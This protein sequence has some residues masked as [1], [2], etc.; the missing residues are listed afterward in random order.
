MLYKVKLSYP[1]IIEIKGQ[2]YQLFPGKEVELPE[3][4]EIVKTYEGLG[5][6]ERIEA[7]KKIEIEKKKEVKGNA[8]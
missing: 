4:E 6:I 1:T 5:Y 3:N 7:G 8:S 2:T